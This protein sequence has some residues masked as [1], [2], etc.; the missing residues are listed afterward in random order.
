VNPFLP[1]LYG[2]GISDKEQ[3]MTA[4]EAKETIAGILKDV[5]N[6]VTSRERGLIKVMGMMIRLSDLQFKY[7]KHLK[8][9]GHK[10]QTLEGE[11]PFTWAELKELKRELAAV[12]KAVRETK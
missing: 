8:E 7:Q 5:K 1:G 3:N 12:R 11:N 2:L 6:G 9:G 4:E 10:I